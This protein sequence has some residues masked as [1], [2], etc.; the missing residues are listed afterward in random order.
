MRNDCGP[1]HGER[2]D[3][4]DIVPDDEEGSWSAVELVDSY[5]AG[6]LAAVPS[7]ARPAVAR[8]LHT[9]P[10]RRDQ[11]PD[12]PELL[13]EVDGG[14]TVWRIQCGDMIHRDRCV[15]V[16]VDAGEIV[17]VGPP[18]ETARMTTGQVSQLRAALNEAAM[19][20]ERCR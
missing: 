9:A 19:L 17:V 12:Q 2:R 18:G 13:H 1:T 20:A 4:H 3:R 16:F 15:T 7:P 11:R 6:R 5:A 8:G 10:V 14:H